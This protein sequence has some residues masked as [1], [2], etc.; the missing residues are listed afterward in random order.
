MSPRPED[1]EHLVPFHSWAHFNLAN[2]GQILFQ[3]LE[4]ARSQ[5]AVGHLASAKPD[6]RFHFVAFLQPFAGVLHTIAVVVHVG[7]WAKLN[8]LDGDDDLLLL[9]LVCFLLLF[10][11]K[12]SVIDDL[13]NGRVGIWRD[14][15]QIHSLLT[16]GANRFAR[17]HH[18]KLLSLIANHA[19]LGHADPFVN[20]SNRRSPKIRTATA[21]KTCS[22]AAPPRFQSKVASPMSKVACRRWTLDVRPWTQSFVSARVLTR[23]VA[24]SLN[25]SSGIA[26]MSPFDRSRT[27]TCPC[28]IS[29]SPSTSINGIFCNCASRIFAPILSLRTFSSTRNPAAR[30][31]CVTFSAYSLIR[32]V[33]GSTMTCTGANQSGNAPA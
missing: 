11:L 23:R 17:V 30:N 27:A 21:A 19:H 29:R 24:I 31:S 28:S 22:Y 25:S 2:I 20:S 8:F 16:R 13:A 14:F 7:A 6:C 12:L 3:L 33:I 10:V 1:S 15:N 9:S 5:F 18:P 26:P 4:D 32:S